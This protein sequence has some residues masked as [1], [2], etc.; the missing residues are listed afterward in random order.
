MELAESST[1]AR[2]VNFPT[3]I[4]KTKRTFH[5][6]R[7]SSSAISLTPTN[8]KG[9]IEICIKY[10]CTNYSEFFQ[11]VPYEIFYLTLL[12]HNERY[13]SQIECAC[14]AFQ[15]IRFDRETKDRWS[16]LIKDKA[17]VTQTE[18][19]EWD[20]FFKC[21]GTNVNQFGQA[22]KN[23]LTCKDQKINCLK[24]IGPPSTGKTM[25][26]NLIASKF[27]THY[28]TM[29]G[30]K[31]DF[32]YDGMCNK[33]LIVVEEIFVIPQQADDFKSIMCGAPLSVNKKFHD[34]QSLSRTPMLIT[35]N[36]NLFGRGHLAQA[37][38]QALNSRCY[39]FNFNSAFHPQCSMTCE[40][41]MYF[42]IK[43]M[44]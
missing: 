9:L 42:L 30:S 6:A 35:S 44:N 38:E 36:H 16:H 18:L 17:E 24:L 3:S 28:C 27:L 4:E 23:T 19:N 10:Q 20:R 1:A 26:V 2:N 22:I 13:K 41:L 25:I 29:C 21:H 5:P 8:L 11:K 40:G 14:L 39:I 43:H 34:K 33:S 7:R 37:D 12:N 15:R 31:S 32:Y